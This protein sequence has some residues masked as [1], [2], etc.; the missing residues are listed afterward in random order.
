MT[1]MTKYLV[2]TGRAQEMSVAVSVV[3]AFFLPDYVPRLASVTQTVTEEETDHA[4]RS[5]RFDR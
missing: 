5:Y 4:D 2:L 1:T 3:N